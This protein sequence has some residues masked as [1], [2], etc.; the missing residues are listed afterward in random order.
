MQTV[1]TAM[2]REQRRL[3]E[4]MRST[5]TDFA[6]LARSRDE[7]VGGMQWLTVKGKEYL[8]RYR[9]D[10]QTGDQ[11]STSLGPR[12]PATETVYDR[13]IKGRAEL[14]RRT[15]ELRPEL[16]EQSR[17][18]K[19]LRL[20]RTP[21]E[22]ADVVRAVAYSGL[23][24]YVS[25]VGEAAVYGYEN[26]LA[27]H[28][29]RQVL[30]DDGVDLLVDGVTPADVIEELVATLRRGRVR[31]GPPGRSRDTGAVQV[32]TDEGLR[33]RLFT[34]SQMERTIDQYADDNYGRGE[35]ARWAIEQSPVRS[36]CIDRHGRAA[37]VRILE[38]RAWCIL[39]CMVL[40]IREMSVTARE[41]ARELNIS[42]IRMVQDRWQEPFE[43][44]QVESFDLLREA[45]EG[46]ESFPPTP[47]F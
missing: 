42:M 13:F 7:F 5:A 44:R 14:D 41:T 36:I 25:L 31:V 40:D 21:I 33:I 34:S 24:D 9:R 18:A 4:A 2:T 16:A 43:P 19:A 8:S 1:F 29:P 23:F 20:N 38:P 27:A 12:S 22:V 30:P 15:E 28:L 11:K 3:V 47:R 10:P 39:R 46:D 45:L 26:E 35:D 37:P 17:L 32:R 6:D